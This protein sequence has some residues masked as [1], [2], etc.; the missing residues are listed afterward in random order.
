MCCLYF[1]FVEL[2]GLASKHGKKSWRGGVFVGVV[3][4][5]PRADNGTTITRRAFLLANDSRAATMAPS[6]AGTFQPLQ[7]RSGTLRERLH[8]YT[9]STL[10]AGGSINEAV[11]ALNVCWPEQDRAV[12][13]KKRDS[14]FFSMACAGRR[15]NESPHLVFSFRQVALPQG[16]SCAAWVAVHAIDFYNDV[17][18]IWAVSTFAASYDSY[19]LFALQSACTCLRLYFLTI[20]YLFLQCPRTPT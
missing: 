10:G 12:W 7:H 14:S 18:T 1:I 2:S 17:S 16:E 6:H 3:T 4:R 5:K 11:R 8:S 19:W 15:R 20:F 9:K 13:K